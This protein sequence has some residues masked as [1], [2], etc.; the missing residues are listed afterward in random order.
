MVPLPV[1]EEDPAVFS[2]AFPQEPP[3]GVSYIPCIPASV[4]TGE[5][6]VKPH[7]GPPDATWCEMSS[8]LR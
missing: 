1:I 5:T 7:A 2:P 8:V 3:V 4:W 6:I